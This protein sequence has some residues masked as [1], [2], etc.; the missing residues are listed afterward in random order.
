L[1]LEHELDLQ[2]PKLNLDYGAAQMHQ[3]P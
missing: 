3:G 2:L 1:L